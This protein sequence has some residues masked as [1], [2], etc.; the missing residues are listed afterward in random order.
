MVCSFIFTRLSTKLIVVVCSSVASLKI[1][2]CYVN[3]KAVSLFISLEI[4][5]FYSLW[6]QNYLHSRSKYSAGYAT[7]GLRLILKWQCALL[8]YSHLLCLTPDDFT[9][10]AGGECMLSL[11][12]L[13]YIT[14]TVF[15]CRLYL[16]WK[17]LKT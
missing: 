2:S 10:H 7:G 16:R 1:Y 6:T 9:R 8:C 17:V 4:H 5:C 14:I 11:N 15:Q 12:E 3:F 13:K